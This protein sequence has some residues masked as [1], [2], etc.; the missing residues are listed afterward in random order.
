[1]ERPK[2]EIIHSRNAQHFMINEKTILGRVPQER[3]GKIDIP[4]WH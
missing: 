2:K 3:I 4:I 1:M